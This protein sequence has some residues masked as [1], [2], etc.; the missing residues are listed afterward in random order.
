M[1]SEPNRGIL[2][3]IKKI[4]DISLFIYRLSS[5]T[6][7]SSI[8]CSAVECCVNRECWC[9]SSEGLACVGQDEVVFLLECLPQEAVP[10]KDVF[11]LINMLYQDAA[12]G[13]L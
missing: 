13:E 12:K 4:R 8:V 3:Q 2:H 7:E 6:T 5:D 1:L 11:L 9:F 10:P